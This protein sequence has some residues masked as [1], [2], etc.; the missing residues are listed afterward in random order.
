MDRFNSSF[1]LEGDFELGP[2]NTRLAP[3]VMNPAAVLPP[4]IK[5]PDSHLSTP[6]T[7]L[8]THRPSTLSTG[9]PDLDQYE[10]LKTLGAGAFGKVLLVKDRRSEKRFALK[11][12]EKRK[13]VKM[14]QVE[15][16]INERNIL[17]A[18]DCPFIVGLANSFKDDRNL[19]MVLELVNGGELFTHLRKEDHFPESR[20]RFYG[21][22]IA[23]ALEY[24]H[25]KLIVHR[26]LK[27]ENI[28][29]DSRGYVKLTDFGFA[30][31]VED[32]TYTMCGTPEYTSPEVI[33][34]KGHN[35]AVDWWAFGV[36]LYEMGCGFTPFEVPQRDRLQMY[37]KILKAHIKYPRAFTDTLCHLIA[38]LLEVEPS[39]RYGS[40]PAGVKDV[41][42]HPFFAGMDWASVYWKMVPAPFIPS[43]KNP[44]DLSNFDQA[45]D[46]VPVVKT[47]T[48]WE[49]AMEFPGF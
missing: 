8:S 20:V 14:K 43:I 16:T 25:Q 46:S 47:T 36:L 33:K 39:K 10:L 48:S 24:L 13:V 31:F 23:L 22:Q 7:P 29:F 42:H 32:R 30:K 26:D 17:A 41:K 40:G 15:H 21:A 3:L 19:Y 5:I 49:C 37:A 45:D 9:N 11:V 35:R 18:V 44:L 34:R 12:L 4:C 1:K 2:P 28:I 38:G 6:S 27:P